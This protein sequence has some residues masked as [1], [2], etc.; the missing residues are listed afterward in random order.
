[1]KIKI[2]KNKSIGKVIYIVEGDVTEP[3]I[4]KTIFNKLLNY[5]VNTYKKHDDS[6]SILNSKTNKYSKVY[7]I[8]SKNP[9]INQIIFIIF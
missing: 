1:M 8:P 9:Q 5:E 6:Y 3:A 4:I 7:V 2:N